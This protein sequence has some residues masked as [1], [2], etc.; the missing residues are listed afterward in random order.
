[1]N[2]HAIIRIEFTMPSGDLLEHEWTY[3]EKEA[4]DRAREL[5]WTYEGP[6]DWLEDPSRTEDL[7][8]PITFRGRVKPGFEGEARK[9]IGRGATDVVTIE[10]DPTCEWHFEGRSGVGCWQVYGEQGQLPYARNPDVEKV[11]GFAADLMNAR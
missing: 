5:E 7:S 1:M 6:P 11:L 4:A 10:W 8:K 2:K 3:P 9:F